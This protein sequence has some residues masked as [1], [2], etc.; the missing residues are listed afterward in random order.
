MKEILY[1]GLMIVCAVIGYYSGWAGYEWTKWLAM[2]IT[3][4]IFGATVKFMWGHP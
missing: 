2:P 1:L 3:S 4:F